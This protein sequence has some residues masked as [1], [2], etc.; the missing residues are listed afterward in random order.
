MSNRELRPGDESLS[1]GARSI[2]TAAQPLRPKPAAPGSGSHPGVGNGVGNGTGEHPLQS[3]LAALSSN[4]PSSPGSA[5]GHVSATGTP[6]RPRATGLHATGSTPSLAPLV[7]LGRYQ[8]VNRIA[9]GGMA[10]VY[11]AVHG[12]LSGFRTPVVLK[13]VLPHLACN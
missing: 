9:T 5:P 11:L 13:K 4:L 3:A 6:S 10:E 8:V 12:E 1:D 2:V 7:R